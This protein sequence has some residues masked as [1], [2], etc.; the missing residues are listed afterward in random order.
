M[1]SCWEDLWRTRTKKV[2][3]KAVRNK[4]GMETFRNS[5]AG[6]TRGTL[7]QTINSNAIL[8]QLNN[9]NCETSKVTL[10]KSS[11]YWLSFLQLLCELWG[12]II[13]STINRCFN[14]RR[15]L[16]GVILDNI[17]IGNSCF[18]VWNNST[19]E[20]RRNHDT[21]VAV[22]LYREEN[23]PTISLKERTR[24]FASVVS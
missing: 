2:N 6:M 8:I 1:H 16:V 7:K 5:N 24:A 18:G 4:I 12:G 10:M 15:M 11:D 22:N 19:D 14:G 13:F 20:P 21:A 23:I 17:Q 3:R 9:S